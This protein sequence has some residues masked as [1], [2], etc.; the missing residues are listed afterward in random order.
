MWLQQAWTK[1]SF[2]RLSCLWASQLTKP[3][4]FGNYLSEAPLGMGDGGVFLSLDRR[5]R[6][7]WLLDTSLG[8]FITLN[9]GDNGVLSPTRV[10]QTTPSACGKPIKNPYFCGNLVLA[11]P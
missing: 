1:L 3:G 5:S 6:P 7:Q 9:W 11:I 10:G 8:R 2:G 4:V